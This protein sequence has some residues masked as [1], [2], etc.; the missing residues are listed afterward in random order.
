MYKKFF[1]R[2]R[3]TQAVPKIDGDKQKKEKPSVFRIGS[4]DKPPNINTIDF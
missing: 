2:V 3:N 4:F 1:E